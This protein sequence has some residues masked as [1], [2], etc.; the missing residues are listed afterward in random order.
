MTPKDPSRA[1]L[2]FVIPDG[3]PSAAQAWDA[4]LCAVALHMLHVQFYRDAVPRCLDGLPGANRGFDCE[5]GGIA[6]R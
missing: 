3:N 1:S 4:E 6:A 5:E 2:L